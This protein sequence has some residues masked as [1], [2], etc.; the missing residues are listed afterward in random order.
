[1]PESF[2]T[3][4]LAT[5]KSKE[6]HGIHIEFRAPILLPFFRNNTDNTENR[7]AN[8]IIKKMKSTTCSVSTYASKL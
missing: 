5:Y 8:D 6:E 1:V 7:S 2:I 3:I 4:L